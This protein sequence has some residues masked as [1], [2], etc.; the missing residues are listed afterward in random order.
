MQ[1]TEYQK[2]ERRS[3]CERAILHYGFAVAVLT[4]RGTAAQLA[5]VQAKLDVVR[6]EL[7]AMT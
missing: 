2:L 7:A 6:A 3:I 4:K 5:E 1:F